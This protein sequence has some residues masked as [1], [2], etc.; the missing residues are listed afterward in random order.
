[1]A[2]YISGDMIVVHIRDVEKDHPHGIPFYEIDP[3]EDGTR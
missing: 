3:A 2:K 1:M